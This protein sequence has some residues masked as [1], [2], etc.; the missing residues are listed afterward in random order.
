MV[1]PSDIDLPNE[2]MHARP[3]MAIKD[4]AVFGNNATRE[5]PEQNSI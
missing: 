3:Y 2:V 5:S 1:G 4:S